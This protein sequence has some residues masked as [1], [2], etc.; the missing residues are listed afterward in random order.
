MITLSDP[1]EDKSAKVPAESFFK[2][3]PEISLDVIELDKGTP[4]H[5][6]LIHLKNSENPNGMTILYCHGN[7]SCLG[8]LY[9]FMVQIC[10]FGTVDIVAMEYPGYGTVKGKPTDEGLIRNAIKAYNHSVNKLN[11]DPR[12]LIIA[13]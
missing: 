7:S 12:K 6:N 4:V 5:T 11:I 8:R 1:K 2:D 13:G 3:D 10:K 9:P